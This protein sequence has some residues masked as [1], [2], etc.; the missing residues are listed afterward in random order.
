MFFGAP[1][2]AI[3]WGE[4]VLA[5]FTESFRKPGSAHPRGALDED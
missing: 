5:I 4:S 2:F 3:I 1:F